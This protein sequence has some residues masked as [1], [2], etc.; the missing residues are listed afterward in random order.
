[1]VM[2]RQFDD[3]D[4]FAEA[5][6]PL[7]IK[8]DQLTPGGFLGTVN[9]ANFGSL[10]FTHINQNQMVRAIGSK[11]AHGLV[12]AIAL[13]AEQTPVVSH[14]CPI[15]KQ[16]IFGFDPNREN[17]VMVGKNAHI[18]IATVNKQAFHSLAEKMGY[19]LG[20]RFMNQNYQRLHAASLPP[21]KAYY[22]QIAHILSSQ[23]S[24]LMQSEMQSLV[25]E[26]F[27]PLLINTLGN[28]TTNNR[29]QPKTFRR[30]AL[31]KKAEAVARAYRDQPLTLQQLG[32]ELGTSSTALFYGFQE[33]FGMSPMAYIKIQRLN[34]V[35]RALKKAD[36]K[37]ETVMGVALKW[38]FWSAG[39]FSRDY[40]EMFG[41]SPSQTLRRFF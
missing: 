1:M 16:D 12:F 22:Q 32:D 11:S 31:V 20:Q 37:T 39:H 40:K 15:K 29:Q 28:S 4:A 38:G 18:V 3:I 26:D 25:R 10:E 33:M 14:G 17:D 13:Q 8:V 24:L 30:Y 19:Y 6:K 9:F 41:E 27:L 23:R 35:S 34:G 7:D 21:L 5:I 36:S 2:N